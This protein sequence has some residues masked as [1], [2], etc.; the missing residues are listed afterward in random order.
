MMES[1]DEQLRILQLVLHDFSLLP[2]H[3]SIDS[4]QKLNHDF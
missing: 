1:L 2:L 4:F 3:S